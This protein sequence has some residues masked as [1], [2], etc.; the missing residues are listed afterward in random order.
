MALCP[1]GV[2]GYAGGIGILTL[3]LGST[4]VAATLWKRMKGRSG[5]N[6]PTLEVNNYE[7]FA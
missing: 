4:L 2:L 1:A 5:I 3:A 7:S 6:N